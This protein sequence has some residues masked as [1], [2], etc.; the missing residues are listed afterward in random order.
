MKMILLG[1]PGAGKGTVAKKAEVLLSIPHI[2]T[3][4]LFREHVSNNTELGAKVKSIMERGDLVPNELTI[5]MVRLRL[6]RDDAQKGFILD[7]FPRTIPQAESLSEITEIDR[8]INLYCANEELVK[9]L[10]GRRSCPVCGRLYH[11]VFVPPKK[12]GICD[13]DGAGLQIRKD[14]TLEAVQNRLN[15]YTE[16]TEPLIDWYEK[17]RLLRHVDGAGSMD[18]VFDAIRVLLEST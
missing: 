5:A 13:D 15:V 9:R 6:E 8:V 17:H 16:A 4:D 12:E 10:T 14:D 2:S 1:P 3:G 18:E 11:T 7:G